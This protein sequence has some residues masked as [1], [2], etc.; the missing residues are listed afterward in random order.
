MKKVKDARLINCIVI[1]GYVFDKIIRR[2]WDEEYYMDYSGTTV[3]VENE[4][5]C[6]DK[7]E[8]FSKLRDYLNVTSV[9]EMR[10]IDETKSIWIAYEE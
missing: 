5:Y 4:K 8:L 6:I 9:T 10:Y 1:D 7:D 2:I 3:Y